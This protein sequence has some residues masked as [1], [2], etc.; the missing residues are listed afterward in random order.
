MNIFLIFLLIVTPCTRNGTR[1]TCT[2]CGAGIDR[3]SKIPAAGCH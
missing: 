3:Y 1:C 2:S